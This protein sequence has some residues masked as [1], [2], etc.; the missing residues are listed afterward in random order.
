VSVGERLL[1]D[2][3]DPASGALFETTKDSDAVGVFAQRERPFV[4]NVAAARFLAALHA[5][6]GEAAWRE[7][8]QQVLAGISTPRTI[9]AQGRMVGEF[10]LAADELGVIA[11]PKPALAE[12]GGVSVHSEQPLR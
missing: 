8:G 5:L 10:L 11:W 4:H 12:R 3:T 1:R 7:R 9:A 6:T 2:F